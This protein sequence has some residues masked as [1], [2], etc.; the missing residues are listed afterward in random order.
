MGCSFLP[1]EG[2]G[3][4]WKTNYEQAV[5]ESKASSKPLV[6]FFTGSDWCGWC[7]RLD[8]EAFDTAEFADGTRDKFIFVKLDYPLY[9]QQDPQLKTQNQQ[10]K[11]KFNIRSYPTVIIWDAQSNQQ[12]GQTG[13]RPGGGKQYAAH[14]SQ[15]LNDYSAYK[16]KVSTLHENKFSG[17]ELK[18]LHE[19]AKELQLVNDTTQIAKVGI[20]SDQA[21]Y[22]LVERY[23]FLVDEGLIHSAE[24]VA[25][26]QQLFALDP[27]NEKSTHYQIAVIDFEAYNEEMERNNFS[28]DLAIAPLTDYIE[29]FGANDK[30]NLWR[31][32]MI[33][34]QV[35]LDKNEMKNA[36][37]HAE[38]SYKAAPSSVQPE[39]AKAIKNIQIQF[40]PLTAHVVE[41]R[42]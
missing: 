27:K 36:L 18:Q 29:K 9:S 26:K 37:R 4:N 19:K 28:A 15:M 34:S 17:D 21:L 14:L 13:Y 20:K 25:I 38:R 33:I 30:E 23:H 5:A 31:L 11:Q 41:K 24:A 6:L 3:V 16:Q 39:I 7:N 35:Y 32:Q 42:F 2:A 22:F 40:P 1:L 10:L 8:E 12:I